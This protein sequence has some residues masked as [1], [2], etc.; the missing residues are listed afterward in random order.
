MKKAEWM[1]SALFL[2][3]LLYL[4]YGLQR[5]QHEWLIPAFLCLFLI[6]WWMVKQSMP[7][8]KIIVLGMLFRLSLLLMTPNLSDDVYRFIWDGNLWLDGIHPFLF[9]PTQLMEGSIE[10]YSPNAQLF[11]KLNSPNYFSIYPAFHQFI[12]IVAAL[13]GGGNELLSIIT[14]RFFILLAEWGSLVVML[15]LLRHYFKPVSLLALYAFNPLVILELSGNLHFEAFVVFFLSMAL[16]AVVKEKLP[17]AAFAWVMAITTKLLPLILLP[18]IIRQLDLKRGLIFSIMVV[19][20][21]ILSFGLLWHTQLIG[22]LGES[23]GLYFQK[24]EFNGSIYLLFRQWGMAKMGYNPIQ[25]LGPILAFVA[26]VCL[27]T[28][29]FLYP[30]KYKLPGWISLSFLLFF[31]LSTTVHPWY[32]IPA[33]YF[34]I[35]GGLWFPLLWSVLIVFTYLQYGESSFTEMPIIMIFEYGLLLFFVIA[36]LSG[37]LKTLKIKPFKFI[38]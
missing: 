21:S 7:A 1:S 31:L 18:I 19:L 29:P 25:M 2:A 24:F 34:G 8:Q 22:H 14:I 10:N 32:I 11:T 27:F 4:G 35:I 26:A 38:A 33:L 36:E 28:L 20:G 23:I 30:K 6:S 16:L 3:I 17:T 12:F 5:W 37:K 15:H 9:T 13:I